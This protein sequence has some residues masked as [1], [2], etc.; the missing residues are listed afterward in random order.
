MKVLAFALV[1]VWLG[2]GFWIIRLS[3]GLRS[4]YRPPFGLAGP[5]E[6]LRLDF[7]TDRGRTMIAK[8]A[9]ALAVASLV[10]VLA[11]LV[12]VRLPQP[13]EVAR[14]GARTFPPDFAFYITSA[15][16]FTAAQLAGFILLLAAAVQ[17]AWATFRPSAR[18]LKLNA[19][20]HALYGVGA[21]V[22]AIAHFVLLRIGPDLPR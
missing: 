7:Y 18:A 21:I 9:C 17:F 22:L 19:K 8:A 6:I 1:L 15:I 2:L 4:E 12:M 11:S 10:A 3:L 14:P 13:V 16:F 20:R 5:L